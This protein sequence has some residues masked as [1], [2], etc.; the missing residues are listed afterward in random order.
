M[1]STKFQLKTNEEHKA[2]EEIFNLIIELMSALQ[3]NDLEMVKS[4][5]TKILNENK[6]LVKESAYQEMLLWLIHSKYSYEE[7]SDLISLYSNLITT[8]MI[9]K[10]IDAYFLS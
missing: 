9:E 1:V 2:Y 8:Q 6:I 7:T 10:L 3:L 5:V 4:I